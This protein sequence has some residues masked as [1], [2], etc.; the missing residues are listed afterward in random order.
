LGKQAGP[1][2]GNQVRVIDSAGAG[3]GGGG[4]V[5]GVAVAVGED[6]AAAAAAV[7]HFDLRDQRAAGRVA[8]G[9]VDV[10]A[11]GEVAQDGVVRAVGQA[12]VAGLGGGKVRHGRLT[13]RDTIGAAGGVVSLVFDLGAVGRQRRSEAVLALVAPVVV[14]HPDEVGA[15]AG[16]GDRPALAA[17]ATVAAE[18]ADVGAVGLVDG[19]GQAA[20]ARAARV[21]LGHHQ[22]VASVGREAPGVV[23]TVPDG[24]VA[25]AV[26]GAQ[27]RA[28][29]ILH[30]GL[31]FV[32]E[33]Q[34]HAAIAVA[35]C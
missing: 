14:C 6:G 7:D 11:R 9:Q 30:Q 25:A 10:N 34:G 31:G 17:A 29:R 33:Q 8:R 32:A 24:Q 12:D 15:A 18:A 35:G 20:P 1:A 27:A 2:L 28:G 26:A 5:V 19:E 21:L 13:Q 4:V 23:V 3:G 16:D 22:R